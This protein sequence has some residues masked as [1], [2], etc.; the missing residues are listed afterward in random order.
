MY[1]L[2]DQPKGS[3]Y[4]IDEEVVLETQTALLG[5]HGT[6]TEECVRSSDGFRG[7][8]A[9]PLLLLQRC[10]CANSTPTANGGTASGMI[11][12]ARKPVLNSNVSNSAGE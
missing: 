1:E 2:P 5:G 8:L 3:K 6:G 7:A 10:R 12:V 4:V 9:R 11:S